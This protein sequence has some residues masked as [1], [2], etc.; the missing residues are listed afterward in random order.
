MLHLLK[1]LF[2]P[3]YTDKEVASINDESK[4][5]LHESD[6]RVKRHNQ[7]L[8]KNGVTLRIYIAT[9]GDHRGS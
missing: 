8:A 7:L 5:I 4:R 6:V 2:L 3:S 1:K 9:G